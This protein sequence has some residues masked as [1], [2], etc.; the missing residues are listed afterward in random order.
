MPEQFVIAQILNVLLSLNAC[1]E[2]RGRWET[3]RGREARED[4]RMLQTPATT[5]SAIQPYNY[6]LRLSE[7]AHY[8]PNKT[9]K[10]HIWCPCSDPNKPLKCF[11]ATCDFLLIWHK[12]KPKLA[13]K[14]IFSTKCKRGLSNSNY[15]RATSQTV[16]STRVWFLTVIALSVILKLFFFSSG[17]KQALVSSS[18]GKDSTYFKT[19]DDHVTQPVLFIPEMHFSTMQRCG[20]VRLY[21]THTYTNTLFP[22]S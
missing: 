1:R 11:T 18:V 14:H 22:I 9:W 8:H 5:V 15:L 20:L 21:F 7:N 17:C 10:K 13:F 4:P 16:F 2:Q 19:L 3:R 12:S 6:N